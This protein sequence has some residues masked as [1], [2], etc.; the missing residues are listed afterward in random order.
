MIVLRIL[1]PF[2][3]KRT[4][5]KIKLEGGRRGV[6]LD[7]W[8]MPTW[9][10]PTP[11]LAWCGSL[12]SSHD[13]RNDSLASGTADPGCFLSETCLAHNTIQQS[14]HRFTS[15]AVAPS[16]KGSGIQSPSLPCI[17]SPI[18]KT[19]C[20]V[21]DASTQTD[22]DVFFSG[23]VSSR[24]AAGTWMGREQ[25]RTEQRGTVHRKVPN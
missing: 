21:L 1:S 23:L 15:I 20:L 25:P 4:R 11:I 10:V 5:S 14:N 3:G 16:N 19:P 2:N 12:I 6:T 24:K 18:S 7:V 22:S 17:S 9:K 8:Q 13:V